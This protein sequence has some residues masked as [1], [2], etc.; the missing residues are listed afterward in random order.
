MHR[1]HLATFCTSRACGASS[2][3][4]LKGHTR[5]RSEYNTLAQ[6]EPGHVG[7]MCGRSRSQRSGV[8]V[9]GAGSG[10]GPRALAFSQHRWVD[11]KDVGGRTQNSSGAFVHW[12]PPRWLWVR[13]PPRP[14]SA[15]SMEGALLGR[16]VAQAR[17][18]GERPRATQHSAR[19]G[20]NRLSRVIGQP[21]C[22]DSDAIAT[23][24]GFGGAN[25]ALGL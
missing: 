5:W 18:I 14:H 1:L 2:S 10:Q 20:G 24:P 16:P 15:C 11:C 9:D 17:R 8:R 7:R 19:L 12:C 21:R 13:A 25:L 4:A 23:H 6:V 3:C 22:S